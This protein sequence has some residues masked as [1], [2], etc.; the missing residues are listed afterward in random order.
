MKRFQNFK[1]QMWHVHLIGIVVFFLS[2]FI[3]GFWY[4]SYE[5]KLALKENYLTVGH[6]QGIVEIDYI[7][8]IP[9]VSASL[10]RPLDKDESESIDIG[11]HYIVFQDSRTRKDEGYT[12]D[13]H[14]YF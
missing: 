12:K 10:K 9:S 13:P 7:T 2:I 6:N 11:R 3:C 5:E 8:S 4:K 1:W 14:E